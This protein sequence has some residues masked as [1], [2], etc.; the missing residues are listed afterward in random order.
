MLRAIVAALPVRAFPHQL[1]RCARHLGLGSAAVFWGF[2]GCVAVTGTRPELHLAVESAWVLT[3]NLFDGA[4][5]L[6]KLAPV[7]SAQDTEAAD[8]VAH[9]DLIGSLLL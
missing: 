4:Q 2:F 8:A 9:R 1:D 7:H 5:G 3:K 6:D